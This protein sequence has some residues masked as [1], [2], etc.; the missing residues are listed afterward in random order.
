MQDFSTMA[1]QM[2]NIASPGKTPMATMQG[3]GPIVAPPPSP[4]IAAPAQPQAPGG[5]DQQLMM[6]IQ[7]IAQQIELM[8]GQPATP[9]QIQAALSQ[10]MPGMGAGAGAMPPGG[11]APTPGGAQ[12]MVPPQLGMKR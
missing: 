8:T 1:Q 9:E 4:G 5:G 2:Q 12:P 11:A 7:Q 3:R 6:M 10:V